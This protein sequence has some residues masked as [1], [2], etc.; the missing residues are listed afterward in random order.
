M[1]GLDSFGL[2]FLWLC[3][4]RPRPIVEPVILS[5]SLNSHAAC[6]RRFQRR[7][8]L[9]H[10]RYSDVKKVVYNPVI[11]IVTICDLFIQNVHLCDKIGRGHNGDG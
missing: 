2:C 4:S 6:L 3:E 8:P 10:M 7:M 9:L 5:D 11:S 1:R